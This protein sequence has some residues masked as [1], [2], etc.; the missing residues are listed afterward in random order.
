[1]T[2]IILII[3]LALVSLAILDWF[4]PTSLVVR[5]LIQVVFKF[6]GGLISGVWRYLVIFVKALVADHVNIVRHL[7]KRRI[8]LDAKER[9]EFENAKRR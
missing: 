4:P 7:T 5:P 6:S 9:M 8:D 3:G 2:G 1:M